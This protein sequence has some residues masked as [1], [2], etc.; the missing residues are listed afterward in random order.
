MLGSGVAQAQ[1]GLPLHVPLGALETGA[2]ASDIRC[3][4]ARQ[5]RMRR[6]ERSRLGP[7]MPNRKRLPARN[8][9]NH[10]DTFR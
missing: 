10:D 8:Q 7:A 5:A 2:T 3:P 6:Q 1:V 9:G 4:A